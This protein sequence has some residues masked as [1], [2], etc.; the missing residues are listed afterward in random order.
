MSLDIK[1]VA[2]SPFVKLE[3]PAPTGRR[4]GE[5]KRAV[6]ALIDQALTW[7]PAVIFFLIPAWW[8]RL[9]LSDTGMRQALWI[10]LS[11]LALALAGLK[12]LWV[13]RKIAF[14]PTF[15][16]WLLIGAT[17]FI[18]AGS[19]LG[20][21]WRTSLGLARF[22]A[23][24]AM[25][26]VLLAGFWLYWL[27][28]KRPPYQQVKVWLMSYLAGSTLLALGAI[29]V[30]FGRGY[31]P[32]TWMLNESWL[33]VLA[34]NVLLLQIFT[35]VE[36][37]ATKIVWSTA[38]VVH[39]LLLF[40]WDQNLPWFLIMAGVAVW[41]II[42]I[43][44]VRNL[45]QKNFIQPLQIFIMVVALWL[46]PVKVLTGQTVPQADSYTQ[47]EVV[48][49]AQQINLPT[50][51]WGAGLGN[52]AAVVARPA[53]STQD[54]SGD[55]LAI[56]RLI[57]NGYA[58]IFLQ[59]GII[60]SLI[61]LAG[62]VW[63]LWRG[64]AWWRSIWPSFKNQ[65]MSGQS[66]LGAGLGLSFLVLLAAL[67][68]SGWSWPIGWL[69]LLLA[70]S[71]YAT[72]SGQE[73]ASRFGGEPIVYNLDQNAKTKWIGTALGVAGAIVFL[74]VLFVD[75]RLFAAG[76]AA[77]ANNW[78]QALAKNPWSDDYKFRWAEKELYKLS[79]DAP[80]PDQKDIIASVNRILLDIYRTSTNPLVV[81]RSA[82][83]YQDLASYAE[84]TVPLARRSYLRAL[85]L[86]PNNVA[87]ATDAAKFYRLQITAL[88]STD[89]SASTLYAEARDF[90]V[91]A[92]KLEPDYLPARLELGLITEQTSNI[93]AAVA[94]LE[95]WE[96]ASPQ[97]KYTVARLYFNDNNL[98]TA[99]EKLLQVLAAV[100]NHSDAHYTLG[101]VYYREKNYKDS[102]AEFEKVLELN[103]GSEDVKT[104]IEEVKKK[105]K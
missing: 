87:L 26:T 81:W 93:P 41:L 25:P 37:K 48:A 24:P 22:G 18:L 3:K 86:W 23:M 102:L 92:L 78:E 64:S 2:R 97:I 1:K 19:V 88:I 79:P 94:E 83:L 32:L 28:G 17:V 49:A 12:A 21:D 5:I 67:P 96:D 60:A 84:G 8:W 9:G 35:V 54:L 90:V 38:L 75:Y 39:I 68:W 82:N 66:Y 11:L 31:S 69:A 55:G 73:R 95:P 10:I 100:P 4:H 27:A 101:A 44:F 89:E 99:K 14:T 29:V 13:E 59:L 20:L 52:G 104:K 33:P 46:I 6:G 57:P 62:L 105:I 80:L 42:Q 63:L 43:I 85:E 103:P 47:T 61:F 71:G 36:T 40:L 72:W 56:T 98:K 77:A 16:L 34:I 51:L 15:N 45:W 7:L 58:A 91:K 70:G 74:A 65:T 53:V 50:A 76:R 30:W